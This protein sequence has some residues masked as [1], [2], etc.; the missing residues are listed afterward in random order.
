M[1]RVEELMAKRKWAKH[2]LRTNVAD[3]E[4]IEL[5][6]KVRI[7]KVMSNQLSKREKEPELYDAI[8][9]IAPEW[10][11]DET[12]IILNKDL[13]AK[14]HKDGNK[15]HSWLLWLGDVTSG[16]GLNFDDGSKIEGK[17]KWFKMSG[18]DHHWND[19]HEGGTK[20]SVVLFRSDKKPKTNVM[21]EALQRKLERLRLEKLADLPRDF[22]ALPK[23]YVISLDNEV[24]RKRLEGINFEHEVSPGVLPSEVSEH[25][26]SHWYPGRWTKQRNE[27]FMASFSAHYRVWKKLADEGSPEAIV[28]EDDCVQCRELPEEPLP[29]DGITL[30]G[31]VVCGYGHWRDLGKWE[32]AGCFLD[33][34]RDLKPGVN[35]L[36]DMRWLMVLAYYIPAGYACKLVEEV[37]GATRKSL[38][39][40]DVWLNGRAKYLVFPNCF[41]DR[42]EKSQ[43]GSTLNIHGSDLYCSKRMREIARKMGK[44]LPR[45]ACG[46]EQAM[47]FQNALREKDPPSI[48]PLSVEPSSVVAS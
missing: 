41:A 3:P 39:V 46:A 27:C 37:E 45:W 29:Q 21:Q 9:A 15:E 36:N 14:R 10:W 2:C 20:Y 23:R 12:K 17:Y 7:A 4:N 47:E 32:R 1:E 11:G 30:L 8:K 13:V 33:Y 6:G 48:E 19:P 43:S 31:G 40:T 44:P 25:I 16:G 24:G 34:I 26:R 42:D 22:R 28:C 5:R 18:Q 35:P 38:K